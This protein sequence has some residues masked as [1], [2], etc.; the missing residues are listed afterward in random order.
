MMGKIF[1]VL[2]LAICIHNLLFYQE[3]S[4]VTTNVSIWDLLSFEIIFSFAVSSLIVYIGF[5]V[6]E[7]IKEKPVN[8]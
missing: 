6:Y 8:R 7:H 4:C 2:F 3:P 5:D 1:L